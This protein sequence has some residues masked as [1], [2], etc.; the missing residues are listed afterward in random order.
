MYADD[1]YEGF[2]D[3]WDG[4]QDGRYISPER[5]DDEDEDEYRPPR[6][7]DDENSSQRRRPRRQQEPMEEE[8]NDEEDPPAEREDSIHND[9][10]GISIV[11]SWQPVHPP[12]AAGQKRRVNAAKPKPVNNSFFIHEEEPLSMVIDA[13]LEASQVAASRY[14]FKIVAN[15]LRS[16]YFSLTHT[17]SRSNI[18]DKVLT[19][20]AQYAE[21]LEEATKMGKPT[22]KLF[23]LELEREAEAVQNEDGSGSG[24][25]GGSGARE[26]T[27]T[28]DKIAAAMKRIL[29][30]WHCDDPTC[31]SDACFTGNAN[32]VH[33]RLVPLTAKKWAVA[34]VAE[35][36][37]VDLMNPPKDE[38]VFWPEGAAIEA[39]D[40]LALLTSR[41]AREAHSSNASNITINFQGLDDLIRGRKRSR[42]RSRSPASTPRRGRR[43][44]ASPTST[45]RRDRRQHNSQQTPASA[46]ADDEDEISMDE[47]GMKYNV[48]AE[49]KALASLELEGPHL[50]KYVDD[51]NLKELLSVNGL[52]K[53]RR[54]LE[55]W[56]KTKGRVRR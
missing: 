10:K 53:L 16:K 29:I 21:A 20:T 26:A 56:R 13:A 33:V 9:G 38:K 44:R 42:S 8:R 36:S 41:R 52:A 25:S 30:K 48:E 43:R 1:Q 28:E 32:A 11:T 51:G 31:T 55:K 39:N 47:F 23:I 7:D 18:K 45:P 19:T 17:V 46:V 22:I 35:K 4:H 5:D 15:T 37:G 34:W 54:A 12:L 2:D 6:G 14:P 24:G 40:D 49:V 27:E 3:N 50:L